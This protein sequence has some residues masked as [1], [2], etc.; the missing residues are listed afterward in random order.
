[1]Q[2]TSLAKGS[3]LQ[4]L[5]HKPSD[6]SRNFLIDK[7]CIRSRSTVSVKVIAGKEETINVFKENGHQYHK[8]KVKLHHQD[9]YLWNSHTCFGAK[10]SFYGYLLFLKQ[11]INESIFLNVFIKLSIFVWKREMFPKTISNK[12]TFFCCLYLRWD[13]VSLFMHN[14]IQNDSLLTICFVYFLM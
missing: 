3:S 14:L 1:M 11:K 4:R 9:N 6:T 10:R 12:T 13:R 2:E 7:L 5:T 8:A